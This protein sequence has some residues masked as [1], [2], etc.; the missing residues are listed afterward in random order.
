MAD[1]GKDILAD[2]PHHLEAQWS[3]WEHHESKSKDA[4]QSYLQVCHFAVF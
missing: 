2:G 3:V 1:A 4:A